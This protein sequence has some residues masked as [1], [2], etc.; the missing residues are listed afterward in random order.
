M[1][2]TAHSARRLRH[3]Q[4]LVVERQ[5]Q[6]MREPL[7]P[8]APL[9]RQQTDWRSADSTVFHTQP[10]RTVECIHINLP[11]IST[12]FIFHNKRLSSQLSTFVFGCY[13]TKYPPPPPPAVAYVNRWCQIGPTRNASVLL[14]SASFSCWWLGTEK[15]NS[16]Y[17]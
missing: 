9:L 17:T 1:G 6:Q 11:I 8:L 14:P 3:L 16:Y 5:C 4:D 13:H 2:V 12:N 15:E 7:S 10:S